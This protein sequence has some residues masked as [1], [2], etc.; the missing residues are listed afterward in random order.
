M[1]YEW[2]GAETSLPLWNTKEEEKRQCR[3][4]KSEYLSGVRC[5]VN[6]IPIQRKP[7]RELAEQ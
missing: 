2:L 5:K 7:Y 1:E 3:L 6:T 4:G